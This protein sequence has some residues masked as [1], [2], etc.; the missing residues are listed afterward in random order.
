MKRTLIISIASL[1]VISLLVVLIRHKPSLSSDIGDRLFSNDPSKVLSTIPREEQLQSGIDT[2][3]ILRVRSYFLGDQTHLVGISSE[4]ADT[5]PSLS[6]A[7]FTY[8]AP[9]QTRRFLGT[10]LDDQMTHKKVL[11]PWL[12]TMIMHKAGLG[13]QGVSKYDVTIRLAQMA[14]AMAHDLS[15]MGVKGMALGKDDQFVSIE[16]VSSW[17]QGRVDKMKRH[18]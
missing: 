4:G 2:S 15:E 9:A 18:R 1:S 13:A 3:N 8:S 6:V 7:A 16:D 11:S 10:C 5:S 14:P 12:H 17:A